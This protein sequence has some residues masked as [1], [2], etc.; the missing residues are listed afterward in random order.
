MASAARPKTPLP[1]DP[2]RQGQSTTLTSG[3]EDVH[4]SDNDDE[5]IEE[6]PLD[7]QQERDRDRRAQPKAQPKRKK[8]TAQG[9]IDKVSIPTP[10]FVFLFFHNFNIK[11]LFLRFS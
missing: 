1:Q 2:P 9:S 8:R 3:E 10:K 7:V 11:D 5:I 4:L 6:T